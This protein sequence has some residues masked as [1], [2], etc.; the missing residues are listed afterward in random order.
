MA[1]TRGAILAGGNASR[2]GGKPKGLETVG[3]ERILDRLMRIVREVVGEEPLVVANDDEAQTWV[4][5]AAIAPD[6]R[7]NCGSL[8]GV[9][10]VVARSP[11][12]VLIVAWDMP[13]VT[14]DLLRALVEKSEGY[15]VFCPESHGPRGWEPMCG[16]YS[17]ACAPHIKAA[18]DQ[19]DFRSDAFHSAVRVGRLPLGEVQT[20]GDPSVLFFNVNTPDDLE[21]A[22]DMW[23]QTHG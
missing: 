21:R 14:A 9:Y 17:P 12:P 18:L 22:E 6:L 7:P 2:F 5:S 15:D 8:G 3:G 13:F 23:Q 1:Y 10:S 4:A 20:F 11:D 16:V 19:E